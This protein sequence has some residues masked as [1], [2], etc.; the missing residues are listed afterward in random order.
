MDHD[1][2]DTSTSTTKMPDQVIGDA[3]VTIAG[4]SAG[5]S[6]GGESSTSNTVDESALQNLNVSLLLFQIGR[7]WV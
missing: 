1:M 2:D 4:D 7:I 3:S 5:D 6:T